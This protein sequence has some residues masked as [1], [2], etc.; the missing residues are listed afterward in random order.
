MS[1]STSDAILWHLISAI[2]TWNLTVTAASQKFY[3][4]ER[5]ARSLTVYNLRRLALADMT[6]DNMFSLVI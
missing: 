3:Y 1:I 2:T 6:L 5:V 4:V